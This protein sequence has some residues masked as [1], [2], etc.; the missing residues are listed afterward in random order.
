[1]AFVQLFGFGLSH[2]LGTKRGFSTKVRAFS[3][4]GSD[5]ACVLLCQRTIA[6]TS[7]RGTHRRKLCLLLCSEAKVSGLQPFL[8]IRSTSY[9]IAL[10]AKSHLLLDQVARSLGSKQIRGVSGGSNGRAA[11]E[12]RRHRW[13]LPIPPKLHW[14]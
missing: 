4:Y 1:M 5:V 7:K 11:N 12:H 9:G 13:D 2:L 8:F 10:L 14:G 6:K 3:G